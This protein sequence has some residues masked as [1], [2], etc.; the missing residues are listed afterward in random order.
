MLSYLSVPLARPPNALNHMVQPRKT[1]LNVLTKDATHNFTCSDT[2]L[3]WIA[4]ATMSSCQLW[5]L[6]Q[7]SWT[8]PSSSSLATSLAPSP[9]LVSTLL[10]SKSWSFSMWSSSR[11]RL[12]L[13]QR[14]TMLLRSNST[15]SRN[16]WKG[17]SPK[18]PPSSQYRPSL[19]IT[20][21]P[22]LITSAE[23]LSLSK[24][25][26]GPFRWSLLDPSMLTSQEKIARTSREVLQVAQFWKESWELEKKL[27]SDQA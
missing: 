18:K 8:L 13:L 22:L 3:S 17:Q 2:S 6:E 24:I 20:S 5:L 12:I 25:S 21:M 10:P 16:S 19:T 27:K 9:R 11:T 15:I 4:Q 14:S 1:T 26:Q 23:F 7:L